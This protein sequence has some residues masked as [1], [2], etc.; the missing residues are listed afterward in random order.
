MVIKRNSMNIIETPIEGLLIIEPD[1]F[2]DE[3]GFF[4]ETYNAER[5]AKAG[6]KQHFVQNNMSSSSYGVVRGLHF[7]R[8][9]YSQSKLVSCIVGM[10]FDVAVDLREGSKTFGDWFSVVL[11]EEN[12]RQFLIHRALL[13]GSRCYRSRQYSR[14]SVITF[15]TRSRRE[16]YCLQT[17]S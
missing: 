15:T 8:A 11:T 7:Q 12:H 4:M 9:P 2:K 17:H 13:T 10:V 1:V 5:Y 14:I 6:I 3:R 16:V